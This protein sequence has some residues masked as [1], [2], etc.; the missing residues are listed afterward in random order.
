[1]RLATE[2]LVAL[3]DVEQ[4]A[5]DAP[6]AIERGGSRIDTVGMDYDNIK[7]TVKFRSQVRGSIEPTPAARE[8]R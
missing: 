5:T 8:G 7:R 2:K 4:F 3:P 1:M 6:V